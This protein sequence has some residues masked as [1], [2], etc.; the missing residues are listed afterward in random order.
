MI[1]LSGLA[2]R[3]LVWANVRQL[4]DQVVDSILSVVSTQ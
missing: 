2:I 1:Y 4:S 3:D